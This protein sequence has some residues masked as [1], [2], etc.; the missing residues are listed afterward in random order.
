[1]SFQTFFERAAKIAFGNEVDETTH[2]LANFKSGMLELFNDF[3]VETVKPAIVKP[4]IDIQQLAFNALL[5]NAGINLA[6]KDKK[7]VSR[8]GQFTLYN[9]FM[10]W[11]F[12]ANN[13]NNLKWN[14]FRNNVK[15]VWDALS[16]QPDSHVLKKQLISTRDAF[17]VW[18]NAQGGQKKDDFKKFIASDSFSPIQW[19]SSDDLC[20]PDYVPVDDEVNEE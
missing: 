11:S 10:G 7:K 8:V 20:D 17:L 3:A 16:K 1:M 12:I 2:D 5:A 13:K 18:R 15:P 19:D 6:P 14:E 4:V 9:T